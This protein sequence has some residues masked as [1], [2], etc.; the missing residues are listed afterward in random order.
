M[1]AAKYPLDTVVFPRTASSPGMVPRQLFPNGR[2]RP[3]L[4]S[5]VWDQSIIGLDDRLKLPESMAELT[6]AI[7]HCCPYPVLPSVS[8]LASFIVEDRSLHRSLL[9]I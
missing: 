6:I 9:K 5:S 7:H 3:P 8:D 2:D 1:I 4:C